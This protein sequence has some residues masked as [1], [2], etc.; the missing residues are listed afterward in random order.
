MKKKVFVLEASHCVAVSLEILHQLVASK[1]PDFDSHI[2]AS[3]S[4]VFAVRRDGKRE[5]LS[6]VSLGLVV[7]SVPPFKN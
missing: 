2:P 4:E 3:R 7:V 6:V 5:D 1:I